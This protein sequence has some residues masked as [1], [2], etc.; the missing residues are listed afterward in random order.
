MSRIENY[1]SSFKSLLEEEGILDEVDEAAI[2]RVLAWQIEH[3]VNLC[4]LS[5]SELARRKETCLVCDQPDRLPRSGSYWRAVCPEHEEAGLS[6]CR[7]DEGSR[8]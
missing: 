4:Q 2:K 5:K 3:E 7:S 8:T 1:G 6:E